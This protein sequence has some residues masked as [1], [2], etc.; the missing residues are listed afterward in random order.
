M[1][2]YWFWWQYECDNMDRYHINGETRWVANY[3]WP[4]RLN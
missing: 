4:E 2:H 3:Q 1:F